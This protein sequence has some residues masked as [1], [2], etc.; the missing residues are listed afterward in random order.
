MKG[1]YRKV[2][3]TLPALELIAQ[4]L[5]RR[6]CAHAVFYL[7]QPVSNSARLKSLISAIGAQAELSWE[8]CLVKD[9]DRILSA[10]EEPVASADSKILDAC[11]SWCNLAREVIETDVSSAW[12]LNLS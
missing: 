2:L 1:T 6:G 10:M 11:K 12:I 7:D 5:R 8:V 3:E 4:A 9:P